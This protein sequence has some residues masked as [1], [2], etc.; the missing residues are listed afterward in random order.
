M[1]ILYKVGIITFLTVRSLFWI[2]SYDV[3]ERSSNNAMV[4]LTSIIVTA[5]AVC[6]CIAIKRT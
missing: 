5:I 2:G 1:N 4:L 3:F 6:L